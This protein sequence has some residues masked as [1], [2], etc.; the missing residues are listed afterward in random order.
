MRRIGFALLVAATA[1]SLTLSQTDKPVILCIIDCPAG[2]GPMPGI[3][4]ACAYATPIDNVCD[5]YTPQQC[6]Q[7]TPVGL[8]QGMNMA[9]CLA[10]DCYSPFGGGQPYPGYNYPAGEPVCADFMASVKVDGMSQLSNLPR[11][12]MTTFLGFGEAAMGPDELSEGGRRRKRRFRWEG[13]DKDDKPRHVHL[14]YDVT[15]A[16]VPVI[17]LDEVGRTNA[18]G[19]SLASSRDCPV[20]AGGA[21]TV[22]PFCPPCSTQTARRHALSFWLTLF[23]VGG[24]LIIHPRRRL[25]VVCNRWTWACL[26][27]TAGRVGGWRSTWRHRARRRGCCRG[28]S[29]GTL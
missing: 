14:E 11:P 29:R 3:F 16:D 24:W 21:R 7:L 10:Y 4:Q 17:N 12:A 9:T 2:Y 18:S 19:Q 1:A 22:H 26:R 28:G 8:G 13:R 27:S 23:H 5:T 15:H 6:K 25:M 20:L